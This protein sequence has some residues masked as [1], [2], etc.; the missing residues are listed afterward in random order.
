MYL[1]LHMIH[2]LFMKY[3]INFKECN[4]NLFPNVSTSNYLFTIKINMYVQEI[5]KRRKQGN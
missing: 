4:L 1:I 2:L 5:K 3:N